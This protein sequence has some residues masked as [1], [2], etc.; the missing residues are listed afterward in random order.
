MN[1]LFVG[2]VVGRPG[3][4][5]LARL[6]PDLKNRYDV[7]FTVVNGENAAGG[8]GITQKTAAEIFDSGADVITL[9]NHTFAKKDALSYCSQEPRLLR[10]QNY[11][12]GVPGHGYGVF[13]S[14]DGTPV[15]VASILG[16][17]FM[18]P[19]DCPF[20]AA[21]HILE[22]VR[23]QASVI[24]IDAHAEATSEKCALG[25]Y[26]DGMASALIGTHTHVQT[27]DERV[28]PK[29]TAYIT[30]AGMTGVVDSIL[31]MDPD[32]VVGRFLTSVGSRFRLAEGPA[33]L[34]GVVIHVD[35][36]TGRA[37]G[38]TRVVAADA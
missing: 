19:V 24:V 9:G 34:Q 6:L 13:A 1:I 33:A 2:D 16:R 15:A 35:N 17:T 21:D 4:R 18:D 20:R 30:D 27:S 29:G 3:R 28:L 8:L 32:V 7:S 23:P 5:A 25:R 10:P 12:P 14:R 37:E 22:Q 38:I 31:G 26:L 11:P 36:I